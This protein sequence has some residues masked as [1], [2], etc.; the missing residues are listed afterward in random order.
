[1]VAGH[2]SEQQCELRY[3]WK[4]GN[5]KNMGPGINFKLENC[6]PE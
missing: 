5:V 3:W 2:M 1:M 6:Q 4:F